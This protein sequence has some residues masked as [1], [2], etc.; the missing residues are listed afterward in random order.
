MEEQQDTESE[1]RKYVAER[2]AARQ[3]EAQLRMLLK[4]VLE[5]DAYERLANIRLSNPELYEKIAAVLLNLAQSGQMSSRV[6]DDKLR[7]L[8]ARLTPHRETKITFARK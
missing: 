8:V 6:T 2:L 1:A 5:P 7:A 4:G 3:R